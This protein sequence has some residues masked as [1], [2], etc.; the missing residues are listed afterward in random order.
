MIG[1][2]LN[3]LSQRCNEALTLASVIGRAFTLDQLRALVEEPSE[4]SGLAMNDDQL[5]A[6]L[7]EAL[8]GRVIEELHQAVGRYQFTYAL[9]QETLTDELSLTRRV[10][11]HGRIAET[12]ELMCGSKAEAHAAELAHHHSHYGL[13]NHD[14]PPRTGRPSN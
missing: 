2:R 8:A 1:R 5:L 14:T 13:P 7:E 9:I 11:L 6:V 4:G 10:R 3:R 12:L